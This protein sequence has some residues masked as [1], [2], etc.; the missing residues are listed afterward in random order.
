M[1][2][3]GSV[4]DRDW[5][6]VV[7]GE[8]ETEPCSE[9]IT[10]RNPATGER[11]TEA[12]AATSGDVDRAVRA[13]RATAE[14]WRR[15]PTTERADLLRGVASRIES[16]TEELTDIETL[17]NGKPRGQAANDV[18]VA[19]QRFR[20]FAGGVDKFYG[21][22]VAFDREQVRTKTYEPYGV[23]GVIIPWNWPA[24][25]TGD[26]LAAPLAAGN[27][28]VLKPAPETPLTSLRMAELLA[29]VL[30]DGVV[31]VVS[32]GP[33]AG[34][35]L[36]GHPDVDKVA[37]TGSDA[38]GEKVLKTAAANITPAMLE[39][40]GKNPAIVFPD[41]DLDAALETVVA[42][43]YFNSGQACT[44]PERLLLH[45]SIHD[46]FL[47]RFGERVA[48]LQV[49]DPTAEG[50]QIGPLASR[51]QLERVTEYVELAR[52]EGAREIASADLPTDPDLADGNW[53]APTVF[54][55]VTPDMRVAQEEVF[56]PF[57]GAIPFSDETD[58]I[59]IA[60]DVE[61]GLSAAVFTKDIDR[62]HRV[63]DALR[64]GIVGI[65]HPSLTW[66]GLP[67]GGVKRSGMG[68]KNDFPEAMREFS[69]P[70][71]IELDLTGDTLSL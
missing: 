41:A 8:V 31:N 14:E 2:P 37:F 53:V 52:E 18:R 65:N 25:H 42:N 67:F 62:A 51:A 15:L 40:G 5:G 26:F 7:D 23:V 56:G 35:A 47:T 54:G 9:T 60:N 17:E 1:S 38:T 3:H 21:D 69:Q 20:F 50:T 63:A 66:Q 39:L 48:D 64:A 34:E 28:V 59:E 33:E 19:A 58:A 57:V 24:M 45:E 44:N 55:D 12:P 29:E 16:H 36:V 61:Y 68:R 22:N 30:P 4:V 10:V 49:G 27:T 13:A 46:E 11:I 6:L 32:G 70:K 71:S 43:A